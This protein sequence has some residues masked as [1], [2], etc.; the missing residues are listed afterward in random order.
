MASTA[1][2]GPAGRVPI[3]LK[4]AYGGFVAVLVPVYWWQ[5][6]PQNFLWLSDLA[7]F[8]TTV[9]LIMEL[10]WLAGMAA[11]G[12]L[13]LET[14]WS[15]DFL[16][17]GRLL[18]LAA[19]MFDPA[20]PLYL[21]ALSLFHL[22]LPPTLL[23]LLSGLGYD[24][25]S[26]VRQTLFTLVLLPATWLLTAPEENINWVYGPGAEPQ[27]RIPPLLY[28]A[29]E[30]VAVPL[31]AILPSHLLFKRLFAPPLRPGEQSA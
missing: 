7:L 26:F 23:W 4:V 3:W 30:M 16:F 25:R 1:I 6:G 27:Q 12:V 18:E 9:A 28:L 22:A 15:I 24:R 17:G 21:R 31:L 2:S 10:P 19:Y 13:A 20:K 8:A 5:Y 29:A 14:I 11:V